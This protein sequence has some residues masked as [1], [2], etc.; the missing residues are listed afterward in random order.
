[1]AVY[2]I[3]RLSRSARRSHFRSSP[4]P[5]H[6][7]RSNMPSPSQLLDEAQEAVSPLLPDPPPKIGI[8]LGSG[9]GHLGDS[10]TDCR[11]VPY[12]QIPHMPRVGV[13][14]HQGSLMMGQLAGTAVA[15]L[16][17]RC[18]LYE[19]HEPS[20]V[21]FGVRLLARLGCRVVLLTNAAG[22]TCTTHPPGTLMLL[23]DHINL[24]GQ[25]PLV[26]WRSPSHFLSMVDA[27]DPRL[28]KEAHAAAADEDIAISEGVYV[29]MLGPSYETPA[30]VAY[31]RTIGG[32][33]VGMSTVLE[34]LALR[35][36]GVRVMGLTCITNA[37]AGIEGAVLD[38][39]HV[40]A[41]AN[42]ARERMQ[43][44]VTRWVTRLQKLGVNDRS[45]LSPT[46]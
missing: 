5:W 27:Y 3:L 2:H 43:R 20:R 22:A 26:G 37:A 10:L 32:D 33:A 8:V 42:A 44:L 19:G 23:S 29:G 35:D 30:E 34:T 6:A 36:E 31:L 1:M 7:R 40:Q 14:G 12:E 17:G 13:P 4:R 45:D 41:V 24:T 15:C 21:V 9:L 16:S 28:R 25:S 11:R 39:V 38:H 18:H 46:G